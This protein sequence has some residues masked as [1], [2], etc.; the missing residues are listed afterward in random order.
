MNF[1]TTFAVV[2]LAFNASHRGFWYLSCFALIPDI[3]HIADDGGIPHLQGSLVHQEVFHEE[4]FLQAIHSIIWNDE[5]FP[6]QWTRNFVSWFLVLRFS[7]PTQAFNTECVNAWQHSWISEC[8]HADR[9]FSYFPE[10]FCSFFKCFRHL[11]L[12]CE[13]IKQ[14]KIN[15]CSDEKWTTCLLSTLSA[16]YFLRLP[17]TII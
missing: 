2:V 10:V 8:T 12:S 5:L 16:L 7:C 11:D 1:R 4:V 17:M 3:T 6:T 15:N 14:N 13:Y 9:T